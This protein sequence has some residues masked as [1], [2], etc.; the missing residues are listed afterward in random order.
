MIQTLD[1]ADR[2]R[3]RRVIKVTAESSRDHP[4][5]KLTAILPLLKE[6]FDPE[7]I[8]KGDRVVWRAGY[9]EFYAS[10]EDLP[11]EFEG[12]VQSVG[13]PTGRRT[14]Q[15]EEALTRVDGVVNS[16]RAWE[17]VAVD[18][19][20]DLKWM[21]LRRSFQNADG[22]IGVRGVPTDEFTQAI[23]TAANIPLEIRFNRE[24]V[25]RSGR[26]HLPGTSGKSILY[27]LWRLRKVWQ[28]G[29]GVDV[30]FRDGKIVL[31]DAG[32]LDYVETETVP[33][34]VWG[35]NIIRDD[36]VERPGRQIRIR[37]RG[38]KIDDIGLVNSK[39]IVAEYPETI[40]AHAR[41]EISRL[42]LGDSVSVD[43]MIGRLKGALV[44]T[45]DID[46]LQSND[47]ANGK[48]RQI[49]EQLVGDGFTNSFV[50]F[51]FPGP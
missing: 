20:E 23:S 41:E 17:I 38:Y 45:Y 46:N 8:Q 22:R 31:K 7:Q 2:W 37:V 26:I 4:I 32:D 21:D 39:T 49:H 12:R 43:E 34:F 30:Y 3:F 36:L 19:M 13:T 29:L 10:E 27:A 18:P 24:T 33:V 40:A 14:N 50:T 42:R 5:D 51:G 16:A 25:N 48:A 1:V 44:K 47:D 15:S 11:V 6:K 35:K 9:K 28:D